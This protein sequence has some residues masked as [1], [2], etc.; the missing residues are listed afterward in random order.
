M[1]ESVLPSAQRPWAR[2]L[3]ALAGGYA[4]LALGLFVTGFLLRPMLAGN[5]PPLPG[6]ER[7]THRKRQ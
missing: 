6:L 4:L 2:P 3:A 5:P 7:G 1:A